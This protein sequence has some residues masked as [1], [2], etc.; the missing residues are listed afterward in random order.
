MCER[1]GFSCARTRSAVSSTKAR[2]HVTTL[3]PPEAAWSRDRGVVWSRGHVAR[4]GAAPHVLD[5]LLAPLQRS[6]LLSPVAGGTG[7]THALW[8]GGGG[9]Q[10]PAKFSEVSSCKSLP[11]LLRVRHST[12]ACRI[13]WR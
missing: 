4:T 10:I 9:V 7:A 12:E 6:Y 5:H 8:V 13:E 3:L 2:D 11:K 1:A